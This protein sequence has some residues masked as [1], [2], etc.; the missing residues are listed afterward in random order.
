MSR[1][2]AVDRNIQCRRICRNAHPLH[3]ECSIAVHGDQRFALMRW[4]D[5]EMGRFSF[6]IRR[7]VEFEGNSIRT[8]A[9]RLVRLS[10]PSCEEAIA[11]RHVRI[12]IEDFQTIT[13]V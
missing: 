6:A 5:R 3:P 4:H 11:K 9:G 2:L 7:L 1:P 10:A 8:Y 13:S 12:A